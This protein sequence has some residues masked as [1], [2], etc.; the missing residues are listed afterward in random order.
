MNHDDLL[1]WS[2]H[3]ADWAHEYHTTLRTRPVRAPLNKGASAALLSKSP[4]NDPEPM[5]EIF[6]DFERIVPAGMTHWQHPRFFAYF[7]ANA[8]PRLHAGRAT[9]QCDSRPRHDLAKRPRRHRDGGGDDVLAGPSAWS[10]SPF[11]WHNP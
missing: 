7:P 1:H 5:S 11:Q 9:L 6:A 4:P 3:A 2:K 8:A 10:A